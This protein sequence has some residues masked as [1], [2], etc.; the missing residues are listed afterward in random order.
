MCIRDRYYIDGAG[1]KRV[2]LPNLET[3]TFAAGSFFALGYDPK[4]DLIY[5]SDAK[6]FSSNGEV[7][8]FDRGGEEMIRFVAGIIPGNF[9][10]TD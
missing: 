8:V 4:E 5:A 3:T 6:D 2:G 9:H 7:I 10:F 1:I